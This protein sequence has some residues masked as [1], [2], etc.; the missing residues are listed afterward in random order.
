MKTNIDM[1]TFDG[2]ERLYLRTL[3]NATV[4]A[5]AWIS[6][7]VAEDGEVFALNN[8]SEDPYY[9]KNRVLRASWAR[10]VGVPAKDVEAYVRRK[11]EQEKRESLEDE[12]KRAALLLETPQARRILAAMKK[13]EG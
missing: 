1:K 13:A 9:L 4:Y 12:V 7:A 6:I 2:L 10:A 5:D 11:R 3:N 8:R